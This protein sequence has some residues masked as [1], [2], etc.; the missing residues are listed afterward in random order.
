MRSLGL[1]YDD[2]G[3]VETPG[4]PLGA[5]TPTR[6]GLL[7]RQVAGQEFLSALYAHGTWEQLVALVRNQGSADT[8][9]RDFARR[10]AGAGRPRQLLM[11][12]DESFPEVFHP[13]PPTRLIF[14]PCPPDLRYAWARRHHS[15][16]GYA[17]CGVTHTLASQRAAEWLGQLLVGPF[18]P[19]DALV[20]TSQAVLRMVRASADAYA[21]YLRERVGGQPRVRMRLEVI[22]LGV[23]TN[24]FYPP[25]PGERAAHREA[26]GIGS[27]EVV[28]L[29]VGR[30]SHH[31]KAHPFP[32]FHAVEQAARATGRA[33]RLILSGWAHNEAVSEA[34]RTAA[35]ALAPSVRVTFVD[36]TRPENRFAVWHAADIFSSLS[37]N[38]QETFGLVI[39]EALASG[40]PVI[41]SDWDG[42]RDLITDGET[43]LL[44]P[45][46]MVPGATADAT[47]RLVLESNS[48]EHFLAE[49]S[50]A[51]AVDSAAAARAFT[52]LIGDESE[53]R[54]LGAAA[55]R[56]ALQRF[57][58]AEVIR[59]YE[60]LW[61]EQEE[62]R[63]EVERHRPAQ[64]DTKYAGLY[65]S[66]ELAFESY[67]TR[68][69]GDGERLTAVSD[70]VARL[71]G[72]LALDLVTHAGWAR[73]TDRTQLRAV[74][75]TG[76]GRT[77]AEWESELTAAVPGRVRARATL[78]WLLKYDLLRPAM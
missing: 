2:D 53:R 78:A 16:D 55:R 38:I 46:V 45:T 23:D 69:L 73:Q 6:I 30:L 52:R 13:A 68:W 18:E 7:G 72:L 40:L 67:P 49:C 12:P 77:L 24:R 31:T 8:L 39:A 65:P 26:L 5:G 50:Q 21:D 58:W 48:Y 64:K 74:L 10:S 14:T 36:G 56:V 37:D 43:G 9:T 20:C 75:A 47:T 4:Q 66:P 71:D 44:V 33:V 62:T 1:L 54:R 3:Y 41:A 11:V 57:S 29:F 60:R 28:V 32:L 17:L 15:S 70:A 35:T 42:Y 27:D 22:P 34:F 51:V 19:Y 25:S 59:A 61:N 63:Q 76:D